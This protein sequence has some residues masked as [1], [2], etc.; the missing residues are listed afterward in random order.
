MSSRTYVIGVDIGGTKI[1]TVLMDDQGTV[2]DDLI[3]P[4]GASDG[5][6]AV[7]DRI[8]ESA[9]TLAGRAPGPVSAV[10]IGCTGL[11]NV[12]TGMVE[13]AVHLFW[14]NVPLRDGVHRRLK[15]SAPVA[16]QNDLKAA[17]L[18][19]K[20]YGAGINAD[21]FVY[22]AV[23]TGLGAAA[24]IEDQVVVGSRGMAMELGHLSIYP[25]GRRCRCGKIGCVETH[26]SGTGLVNGATEYLPQYP[27]SLLNNPNAESVTTA[28]ILQAFKQGDV[29]ATRLIDEMRDGLAR[30]ISICCAVYNPDLI[31]LGGGF[32]L[33]AW[34]VLT[35]KLHDR[36]IGLHLPELFD[37]LP[38][39]QPVCSRQ[40]IGAG[41]VGLQAI[42]L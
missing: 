4:T 32:G 7:L 23:G 36:L 27:D 42:H 31:I 3:V 26:L 2:L 37:P 25:Q 40:A 8:A 41:V 13:T 24:V 22:L 18:G 28:A 12:R 39:T 34:D 9:N 21:T 20:R 6:T 30:T 17:A 16:V 35:D 29:L 10:G 1:D 19:E 11:V 15:F 14:Q 38:I 5:A 33:A